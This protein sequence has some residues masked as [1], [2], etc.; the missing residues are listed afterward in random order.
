MGRIFRYKPNEKLEQITAVRL[1]FDMRE[2]DNTKVGNKGTSDYGI[3]GLDVTF[4]LKN[5]KNAVQFT[6]NFPYFL[7]ST[8]KF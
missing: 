4:I 8:Y 6:C 3:H 1:P 7:K 5:R 2:Y